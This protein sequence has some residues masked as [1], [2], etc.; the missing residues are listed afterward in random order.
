MVVEQQ[1]VILPEFVLVVGAF[2]CLRCLL[3]QR[4]DSG[5]RVV[6]YHVLDLVPVVAQGELRKGLAE[7]EEESKLRVEIEQLLEA[8]Q[9]TD[10]Q[11]DQE[12][13]PDSDGYRV[14]DELARREQRLEK[15]EEA[16]AALEEREKREHPDEPIDP[17][18]QVS[19]ADHDA[20][21]F[22]KP[23]DGT[24]AHRRG[25]GSR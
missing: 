21:C 19:F 1:V 9:A 16:K 3:S 22:S 15:I 24:A 4:V 8:A 11:E 14:S 20:R 25:T 23:G 17:K 2:G 18:K 13:S 5:N 12:C 10:E 6:E 7:V